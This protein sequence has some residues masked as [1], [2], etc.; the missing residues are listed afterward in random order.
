MEKELGDCLV[1]I[2]AL[3]LARGMP[4]PS[5]WSGPWSLFV[6]P[7]SSCWLLPWTMTARCRLVV[8]RFSCARSSH[9]SSSDRLQY[10]LNEA[11]VLAL[12]I[13]HP[14]TVGG[15]ICVVIKGAQVICIVASI[16]AGKL[17]IVHSIV[18]IG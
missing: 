14:A 15:V 12:R 5:A 3:R 9:A 8:T 18:T 10:P 6:T 2:I 7:C 1:S 16:C 4:V 17:N 13:Y 11:V